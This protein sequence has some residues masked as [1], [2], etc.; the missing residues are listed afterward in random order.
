M[1]SSLGDWDLCNNLTTRDNHSGLV[2]GDE[3]GAAIEYL[4]SASHERRDE[5]IITVV[6]GIGPT[7]AVALPR[8]TSGSE[9]HRPR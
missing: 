2:E 3:M 1:D 5:G 4:C 9:Y 8:T 7:A 6:E